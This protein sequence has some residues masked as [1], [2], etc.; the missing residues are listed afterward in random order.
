MIHWKI[1]ILN[2]KAQ[3]AHFSVSSASEDCI[4][5]IIVSDTHNCILNTVF[6]LCFIIINAAKIILLEGIE[7]SSILPC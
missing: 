7:L 6:T 4:L 1:N 2:V 5:I 3:I